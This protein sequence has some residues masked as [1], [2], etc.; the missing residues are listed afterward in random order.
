MTAVLSLYRLLRAARAGKDSIT[1]LSSK[2]QSLLQAAGSEPSSFVLDVLSKI[3]ILLLTSLG[4]KEEKTGILLLA[5]EMPVPRSQDKIFSPSKQAR[6]FGFAF[7]VWHP[8]GNIVSSWQLV[9][10]KCT[11]MGS[12]QVCNQACRPCN[13]G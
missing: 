1:S 10:A 12:Q 3:G 11:V 9:L 5:S 6:H 4:G 8:E 2:A 7:S 13:D